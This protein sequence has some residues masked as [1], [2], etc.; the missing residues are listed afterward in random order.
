MVIGLFQPEKPAVASG[1]EA[2]KRKGEEAN[3]DASTAKIRKRGGLTE[4]EKEQI[5]QMV[6]EEEVRDW[7]TNIHHIKGSTWVQITYAMSNITFI[8]PYVPMSL[9]IRPWRHFLQFL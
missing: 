3:G 6:D 4:E 9:F 2:S 1:K 7:M 8:F 5:L